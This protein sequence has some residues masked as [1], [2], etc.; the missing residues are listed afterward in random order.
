M[1]K[2]DFSIKV[3]YSVATVIIAIYAFKSFN[4]SDSTSKKITDSLKLI[5]EEIT[6]ANEPHPKIVDINWKG[7]P[8]QTNCS[9]PPWGLQI[10]FVSSNG[11]IKLYGEPLFQIFFGE[12][13]IKDA[14]I[15]KKFIKDSTRIMVEGEPLFEELENKE[16][17]KKYLG[18]PNPFHML[19]LIIKYEVI[20]SRV[21]DDK[22]YRYFT[23]RII[24]FD[25]SKLTPY[26]PMKIVYE[27]YKQFEN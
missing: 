13:E 24:D 20:Y 27:D 2:W 22:K 25:C 1:N 15:H 10:V 4:T 14:D 12:E 8:N 19:N 16:A 9:N 26:L 6:K 3:V 18:T 23:Q 17:F 11:D 7:E 21:N 5:Q